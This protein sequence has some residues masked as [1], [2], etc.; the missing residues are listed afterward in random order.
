MYHL[1][2]NQHPVRLDEGPHNPVVEVKTDSID[3]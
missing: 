2:G 1:K 3:L